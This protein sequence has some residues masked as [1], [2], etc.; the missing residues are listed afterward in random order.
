MSES[1]VPICMKVTEEKD[2]GVR[3]QGLRLVGVLVGRLGD[4]NMEKY[5]SGMIP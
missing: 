3:E 4:Q 5:L 1:L 2:Q